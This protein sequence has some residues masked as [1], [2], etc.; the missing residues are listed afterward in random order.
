MGLYRRR[1]KDKNG[2]IR[3]NRIWW[4]DYMVP[5]KGQMC[6]STGETNKRRAQEKLNSRKGETADGR[7]NVLRSHAP[8]LKD[9]LAK[10]LEGKTDLN[11]NT[12]RRYECSKRNLVAFFTEARL[13]TIT[14]ARIEDY[15]REKLNR[16]MR[17]A[18]IN[19]DLAFLRLA[20]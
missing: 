9:W 7:F 6:E 10:Y 4:M 14:E 8:T 5:G 3:Q 13:P 19:R 16:G 11:P 2:K 17:S 18:G 1:W 20:L 12:R 15:K